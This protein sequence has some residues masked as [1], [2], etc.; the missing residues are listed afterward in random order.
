ML[1]SNSTNRVKTKFTYPWEIF[2]TIFPP[3]KVMN[4]F[5]FYGTNHK[6]RV[7]TP[8]KFIEECCRLAGTVE[9]RYNYRVGKVALGRISR[10]ESE[11]NAEFLITC[12]NWRESQADAIEAKA[13]KLGFD[14]GT[15]GKGGKGN[16]TVNYIYRKGPGT[17][18][19]A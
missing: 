17:R 4:N 10:R 3:K 5:A 19:K 8:D 9:N 7:C 13:K 18:Q 16:S 2:E 1:L 12:C 6:P 11:H 15:P 14:A